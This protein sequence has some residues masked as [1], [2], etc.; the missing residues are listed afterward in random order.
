LNFEL[1]TV[2]TYWTY[3]LI[4]FA[5][6][7]LSVSAVLFTVTMRQRGAA[8]AETVTR[9]RSPIADRR[10]REAPSERP[11]L[12]A[13]SEGSITLMSR[14]RITTVVPYRREIELVNFGDAA[15]DLSNWRLASPRPGGDDT[16][17]FPIA[18]VILP[19]EA[20]IVVVDEGVD[21][22]GEL[23]WRVAGDRRVLELTG[24]T[25]VLLNDNGVEVSRFQYL[26][27]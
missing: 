19:G 12:V 18:T 2:K 21:E 17:V 10:A 15:E 3:R 27:S 9:P 13:P 26:R 25:V 1:R 14:V 5:C 7:A 6:I 8:R 16:F 20:L 23:H 22:P 11:Q 4:F 24:D